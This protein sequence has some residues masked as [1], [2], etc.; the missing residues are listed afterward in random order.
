MPLDIAALIL[1]LVALIWGAERLVNGS[2][3]LAYHLGMSPLLIGITVVGFGTSSPEL[4][5][6]AIASAGGNP[7]L[8]VGNA[9]GSNMANIGLVAGATALVTPLKIQSRT[10]SRELPILIVV[11]FVSLGLL[12]D[13]T[14]GR[15]DGTVL[16]VGLGGLIIWLF[17]TARVSKDDPLV[18]KATAAIPTNLGPTGAV[19]RF[20][21]GLAVLLLGSR[22]LVW[23]PP[24]LPANWG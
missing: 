12:L 18:A 15:A 21:A 9:I 23:L 7:G 5:V 3:A 14:L 19:G 20:V 8:A 16:L 24:M 11:S 17:R 10:L 1:G 6:A 4:V 2:A 13:G 22:V